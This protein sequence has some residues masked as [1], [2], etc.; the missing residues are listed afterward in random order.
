MRS[1]AQCP[2][3]TLRVAV[4]RRAARSHSGEPTPSSSPAIAGRDT[5]RHRPAHVS[6]FHRITDGSRV[7][8]FVAI[9]SA[10]GGRARGGLRIAP[11]LGEEEIRSGARAMTLK[12]G[13]LGL[14]QGGAKAGIIGDDEASA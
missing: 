14:P 12:Y 4:R 5:A 9:D 2:G 10:L 11:D 7:I 3:A 6:S 13:L 8:G 1:I